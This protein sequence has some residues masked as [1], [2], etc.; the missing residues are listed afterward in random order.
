MNIFIKEQTVILNLF[1]GLKEILS[2]T[3]PRNKFGVT[4]YRIIYNYFDEILICDNPCAE[5]IPV[6]KLVV[7]I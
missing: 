6:G 4:C 3:R 7:K 1:Q 5:G 2:T